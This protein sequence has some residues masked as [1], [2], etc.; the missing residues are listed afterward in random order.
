MMYVYDGFPHPENGWRYSLE[1]MKEMDVKGLIVRPTSFVPR[2]GY[3]ADPWELR[4]ML[5]L[6]GTPKDPHHPYGKRVL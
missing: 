3:P 6:E 2:T 5:L 4:N 1:T